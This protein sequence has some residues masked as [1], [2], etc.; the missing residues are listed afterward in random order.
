MG[1]TERTSFGLGEQVLDVAVAREIAWESA[2]LVLHVGTRRPNVT[3]IRRLLVGHHVVFQLNTC[4]R[5]VEG[6]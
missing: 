5:I 2:V 4:I 1:T 6:E 3:V